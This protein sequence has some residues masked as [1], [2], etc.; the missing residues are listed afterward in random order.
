MHTKNLRVILPLDDAEEIL[1]TGVS[2]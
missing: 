2:S 1:E